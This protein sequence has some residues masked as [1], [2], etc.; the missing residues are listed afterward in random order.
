MNNKQ[1]MKI[2]S[3]NIQ[4]TNSFTGS[5]F[6]DHDFTK[7][8]ESS[9]IVCL[10]E[11]RQPLKISGYRCFNN[12]R[13]DKKFGGVCTMIRNELINGVQRVS[14][15]ISDLVVCKL[16]HTFFN[17]KSDIFIVNAYVKPAN[18]SSKTSD[19]NGFDLLRSI[20]ELVNNLLPRGLV[21]ICG[22]FNARLGHEPDF[23][24]NDINGAD[25]HV[26][27]P[28]DY[29]KDTLVR[30]NSRDSKTN[31]YKRPFLDIILNNKMHILN[32]R[33][34]GD[35][36]GEYTCIQPLGSSVVD[37]FIV[38]PAVASHVCHMVVLPFTIFS[39]HR[40]IS[41]KLNF[42]AVHAGIRK[43]LD[44]EYEKAPLRYKYT[45]SSK[46]D[47]KI[48]QDNVSF[49]TML[50]NISSK[51]YSNDSDG[52]YKLNK[53]ITEYIQQIANSCL[54]KTKHPKTNKLN[55]TVNKQPWFNFTCRQGKRF[56]NKAA[57]LTNK[58][59]ESDYLRRNFYKVK[60]QYKSITKTHKNVFFDKLNEDIEGGK[61]LNWKQFKR[62]KNAK[63][64]RD[65]FDAHDMENFENFFRKLYSNEHVN[66]SPDTKEE[67][68]RKADTNNSSFCASTPQILN[69]HITSNE[70]KAVI[71]SLKNGKSS[72]DD[73]ISNELLKFLVDDGLQLL[74]KLFN[75]CLDSG[76]YPWNNS[77]ISP[78]HKKG[79]KSDPDNYR[80]VAVG[81]VMGKLFSTILL[82]RLIIF[83]NNN[84][85][86]PPNQLGFTKG[87][88][89]YDHILTLNTI[90][91]KYKKLKKPVFAVFVDF[92]KAFDS[93]CR[94]ALF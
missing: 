67:L 54:D 58:F 71:L 56:A 35:L 88:Q 51:P 22:D 46:N 40:P 81:S 21:I 60:S 2:V 94:E 26:P 85:P 61:I 23:I 45:N 6:E 10:Q 89:T 47:F 65:A 3:W 8:F 70:I 82:N 19:E 48:A 4:S 78:L 76:T 53:D 39:D 41:L 91:S 20:D 24:I 84:C 34:L 9:P 73:L 42:L 36:R 87:A 90:V 30:R 75:A 80:A 1:V 57:R 55:S 27:I 11:I 13:K 28:D 92:R 52:T 37:Y 5:K 93:V 33:T 74:V 59:P 50:N 32:G 44:G 31:S 14:T 68:L 29:I 79:C 15:S 86:D 25:S 16:K 64:S 62:L 38:S 17:V 69:T 63:S 49:V 77:I 12:T 43:S 83:K 7:I 66:V 72:S 18:T